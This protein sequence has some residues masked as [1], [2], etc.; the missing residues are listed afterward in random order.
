M[1]ELDLLDDGLESHKHRHGEQRRVQ[2]V[3]YP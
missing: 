1:H 2:P 3:N